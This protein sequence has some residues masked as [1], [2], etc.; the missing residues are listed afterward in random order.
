MD[1]ERRIDAEWITLNAMR[2]LTK[3]ASHGDMEKSTYDNA[4]DL[5]GELYPELLGPDASI[6]KRERELDITKEYRQ[7]SRLRSLRDGADIS[8]LELII[9]DI[10]ELEGLLAIAKS[11]K[12]NRQRVDQLKRRLATLIKGRKEL[13]PKKHTENQL[14]FRDAY[15]AERELPSLAS[16]QGY[17]DFELPNSKILRV[18]VLHPDSP[19]HISGADIIYERHCRES[20]MVSIVAVQYK[21]WEKRKLYLTDPRMQDQLEKMRG[22]LCDKKVCESKAEDVGFRFPC[23]AAFLRPTDRLQKPDQKF[24][25]CG[26][27]IPICRIEECSSETERGA[28]VLEYDNMRDV[29]LSNETFEFLFNSGKIGSDWLEQEE[30]YQ[31]YQYALV[32]APEDR[33]VVYAQE[34][35]K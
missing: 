24:L 29:S 32:N 11:E 27:H 6:L 23:C 25:S 10:E 34:F 2:G 16:G 26:E 21:I 31:L 3:I 30:L 20:E 7:K 17:R 28:K 12:G 15:N 14:I 33:V 19:E 8:A 18:R 5:G 4:L 9:A 22:F 13:E 1:N 35:E